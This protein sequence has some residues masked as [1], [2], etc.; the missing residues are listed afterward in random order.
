MHCMEEKEINT[1]F[2]L[3][4]RK[5]HRIKVL[6]GHIHDLAEYLLPESKWNNDPDA[7]YEEMIETL[8]RHCEEICGITAKE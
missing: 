5:I 3:L 2:E 4:D 8:D 6:E 1:L 7:E